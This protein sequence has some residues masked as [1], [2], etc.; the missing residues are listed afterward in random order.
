MTDGLSTKYKWGNIKKKKKTKWQILNNKIRITGS[1]LWVCISQSASASVSA[2]VSHHPHLKWLSS[3]SALA[4]APSLAR[5]EIEI[6]LSPYHT[7]H[8]SVGFIR[9]PGLHWKTSANSFMFDNVPITRNCDGEC[10][11]FSICSR[12]VSSVVLEHQTFNSDQKYSVFRSVAMKITLT[13]AKDTKKSCE[14]VR[15]RPG[16]FKTSTSRSLLVRW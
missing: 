1:A 11:S 6:A 2:S 8:F 7:S 12:F 4:L 5:S 16:S 9:L 3:C 10:G 13:W 15:F 14:C